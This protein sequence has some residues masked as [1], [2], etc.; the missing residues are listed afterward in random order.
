MKQ[1]NKQD[2]LRIHGGDDDVCR[3]FYYMCET[4]EN[5]SE[6]MDAVFCSDYEHDNTVYLTTYWR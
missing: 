6:C 1:L 5:P 4:F 2:Q 3:S